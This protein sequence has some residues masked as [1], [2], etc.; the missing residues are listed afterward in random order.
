MAFNGYLN[1]YRDLVLK[2]NT[3]YHDFVQRHKDY[4]CGL[5]QV[6]TVTEVMEDVKPIE[7]H[8][9]AF[10]P[11][12]ILFCSIWDIDYADTLVFISYLI[13]PQMDMY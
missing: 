7:T 6:G 2:L 3:S 4:L 10:R 13:R 1:F 5:S 11:V 9:K 8:F 12:S